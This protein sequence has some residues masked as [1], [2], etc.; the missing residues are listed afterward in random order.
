MEVQAGQVRQRGAGI[1]HHGIQAGGPKGFVESIEAS[2]RHV[3]SPLSVVKM[4]QTSRNN[5]KRLSIFY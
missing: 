3:V 4:G 1:Q 2:V 5:Q